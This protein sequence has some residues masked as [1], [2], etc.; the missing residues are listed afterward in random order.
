MTNLPPISEI[1]A[2]RAA[3]N[4]RYTFHQHPPT[5]RRFCGLQSVLFGADQAGI[6]LASSVNKTTTLLERAII[7][8]GAPRRGA[9][10]QT[11]DPS[12]DNQRIQRDDSSR[13]HA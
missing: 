1:Q 13:R 2:A 8:S 9:G 10:E 4:D 11:T 5:I 12:G 7:G 3:T 6:V